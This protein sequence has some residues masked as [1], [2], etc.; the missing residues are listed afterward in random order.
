MWRGVQVLQQPHL[1]SRLGIA[2][3]HFADQETMNEGVLDD[4]EF[5]AA[6]V[7]FIE[8]LGSR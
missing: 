4:S 3:T 7:A 5:T 6:L 2:V 1:S 8:L